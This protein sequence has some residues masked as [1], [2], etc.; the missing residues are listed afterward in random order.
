MQMTRKSLTLG[1]AASLALLLTGL[2]SCKKSNAPNTPILAP[3]DKVFAVKQAAP[4]QA[5]VTASS[6]PVKMTFRL[7]K[8]T[9]TMKE[10][11][12]YQ[13]ILQNVGKKRILIIDDIF[14]DPWAI[15]SNISSKIGVFAEIIGPGGKPLEVRFAGGHPSPHEDF[16][17]PAT[18][19]Q[20]A[21]AD[22]RD[23]LLA[24]WK[25]QGLSGLEIDLKLMEHLQ[26]EIDKKN[27]ALPPEPSR[28]IR[29]EPGQSVVTPPWVYED[30]DDA[31]YPSF[32][33]PR[34]QRIGDFAQLWTYIFYKPGKYRIRLVYDIGG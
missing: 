32:I 16:S 24:K 13:V 14:H 2:A 22:Q 33:I 17:K 9:V 21:E 3:P 34:P 4:A 28:A 7:Y 8:T 18:P 11:L 26:K 10:T 19:A 25:K 12:W 20:V 5:E 31:E 29:L 27:A 30:P 6:G 23:A 1:R 15:R